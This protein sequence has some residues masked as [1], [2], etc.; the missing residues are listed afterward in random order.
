MDTLRSGETGLP[1][2]PWITWDGPVHYNPVQ[3]DEG[4]IRQVVSMMTLP[5][6]RGNYDCSLPGSPEWVVSFEALLVPLRK[7]LLAATFEFSFT[8]PSWE[9][10]IE[11][12]LSECIVPPGDEN[13][14][15]TAL[16][17]LNVATNIPMS[18]RHVYLCPFDD[19][20]YV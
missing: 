15:A 19:R 13:A 18:D 3:V 17:Y 6:E 9:S 2:P 16:S 14:L 10:Y 4:T 7:A 1:L 5:I 11:T 12:R 8:P 20:H